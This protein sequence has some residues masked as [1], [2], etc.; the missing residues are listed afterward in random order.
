M[1][2]ALRVAIM[3]K[4]RS[5]KTRMKP[6]TSAVSRRKTKAFQRP[7]A[8]VRL[9]AILQPPAPLPR[10]CVEMPSG[11]FSGLKEPISPMDEGDPMGREKEI[12]P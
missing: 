7:T 10:P 11:C 6:D 1:R 3:A 2:P 8:G 5:E 12:S 9:V 4:L